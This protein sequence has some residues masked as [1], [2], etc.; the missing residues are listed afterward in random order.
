M[1]LAYTQ[2]FLRAYR[3]LTYE[4]KRQVDAHLLLLAE[5]LRHPS[6]RARKWG[7]YSI[8]YARV[9]RDIRIFFE[10]LEDFYLLLDVGHHDIEREL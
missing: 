6:L 5:N 8:W 10:V 2:R 7:A 1:E 4:E 9:S 3:R